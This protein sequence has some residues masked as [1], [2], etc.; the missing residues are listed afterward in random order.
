MFL[1]GCCVRP[2]QCLLLSIFWS[3]WIQK[4]REGEQEEEVQ[5]RGEES[6]RPECL[7]SL[8]HTLFC[9]APFF[10]SGVR[11]VLLAGL[12]LAVILSK[13]SK[14]GG[15]SVEKPPQCGSTEFVKWTKM[16]LSFLS[17]DGKTVLKNTTRNSH[18]FHCVG[19]IMTFS[20]RSSKGLLSRPAVGFPSFRSEAMSVV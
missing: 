20:T 4:R 16:W 17:C 9:L 3:L 10:E 12:W 2:A 19:A 8:Q 13:Q 6:G 5:R 11:N 1:P 14:W 15:S 18:L 7:T